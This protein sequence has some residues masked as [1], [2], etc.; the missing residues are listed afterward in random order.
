M[1][2][3]IGSTPPPLPLNPPS[4]V[5][6]L[7]SLLVPPT[8]RYR[9]EAEVLRVAAFPRG[10]LGKLDVARLGPTRRTDNHPQTR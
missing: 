3:F 2:D 6:K 9:P 1:V 4:V 8:V 10:E 7:V 5:S